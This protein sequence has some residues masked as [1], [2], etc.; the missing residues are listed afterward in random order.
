MENEYYN[1]KDKHILVLNNNE[2]NIKLFKHF[3]LKKTITNTYYLL[4]ISNLENKLKNFN[5]IDL[6][7]FDIKFPSNNIL[8]YLY[9]IKKIFN[10]PIILYSVFYFEND[11]EKYKYLI[12]DWINKPI[13]FDKLFEEID[14]IFKE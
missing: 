4:D 5:K 1:W 14:N 8:N 11:F 9:N 2:L 3:F 7:I 10:C 6:V 13:N 12:Y